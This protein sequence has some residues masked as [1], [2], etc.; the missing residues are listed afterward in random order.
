METI[1]QD[2]FIELRKSDIDHCVEYIRNKL[3]P[4]ADTDKEIINKLVF[5]IKDNVF[6]KVI[7]DVT[8]LDFVHDATRD[9]LKNFCLPFLASVGARVFAIVTG[10]NEEKRKYYQ[11]LATEMSEIVNDWNLQSGFFN[12]IDEARDW[13]IDK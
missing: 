2:E 4:D 9:Y 1:Y 11:D 3:S 7:C 8:K 5:Q 6:Y 10:E 12:D 13:I